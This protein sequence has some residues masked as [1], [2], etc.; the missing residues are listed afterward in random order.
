MLEAQ[1]PNLPHIST[2][3]FLAHI[4]TVD[5][6]TRVATHAALHIYNILDKH[7]AGK[8]RREAPGNFRFAINHNK[9]SIKGISRVFPAAATHFDDLRLTHF[10]QLS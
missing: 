7:S 2:Q 9:M 8:Y 1:R 5:L 4:L 3:K 10:C 6:K